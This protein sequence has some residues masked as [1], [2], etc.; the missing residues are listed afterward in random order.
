MQDIN[1]HVRTSEKKINGTSDNFYL[2]LFN[3]SLKREMKKMKMLDNKMYFYDEKERNAREKNK[4]SN[5][6]KKN[7]NAL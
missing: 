6:K 1:Y 5:K 7:K 2:C 3:D 4:L